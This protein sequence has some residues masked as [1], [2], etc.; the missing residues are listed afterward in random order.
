VS[1]ALRC[2]RG[3]PYEIRASLMTTVPAQDPDVLTAGRLGS[4]AT[5]SQR[6]TWPEPLIALGLALGPVVALGFTRFSPALLLPAMRT[7]LHWSFAAAGGMN[8][9]NAAGYI[10]GTGT[11]AWW[12]RRL[13]SRRT[14][15]WILA[16]SAV[17][18]LVGGVSGN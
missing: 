16:A 10:I 14:F 9:A 18:L 3:F 17:L 2:P 5:G 1:L 7:D 4:S 13:G 6:R 15:I 11:A 8:S 12:A